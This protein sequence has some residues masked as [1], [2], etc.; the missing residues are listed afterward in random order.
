MSWTVECADGRRSAPIVLELAAAER[1]RQILDDARAPCGPHRVVDATW[2]PPAP[3]PLWR[4]PTT[5]AAR[6]PRQGA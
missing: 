4:R 6:R 1:T 5:V 3:P 2:R